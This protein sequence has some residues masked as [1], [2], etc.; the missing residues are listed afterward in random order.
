MYLAVLPSYRKE[1]IALLRNCVPRPI[2][3]CSPAH[4]EP[5]VKTGID[6]DWYRRVRMWRIAGKAFVQFGAWREAVGMGSLIVDLNPRSITAWLLLIARRLRGR[7]TLV[8]G[9][10]YPR[11][12]ELGRGGRSRLAMR[13]LADGV[14]CY[15]YAQA[16]DA[17]TAMPDRPAW[18]AP[19]ALYRA[20]QLTRTRYPGATRDAAIYVG[21]LESEKRVDLFI[22]AFAIS[23]L[24]ERSGRAIIV[25]FGKQLASLQSLV[26]CLGMRDYVE[27]HER[28]EDVDEL[29]ALY[30]RAFCSVSPGFVGLSL[31]QSF[32]FGVPAVIANGYEHSPEIELA[33]RWSDRTTWSPPTPEGF[34]AALNAV[35][36]RRHTVPMQDV[37]NDVGSRYSAEAMAAGLAEALGVDRPQ[38]L[39]VASE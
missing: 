29:A 37:I 24:A 23:G 25:G 32:G 31:T 27:F 10:L 21:R 8:W 12:H 5:S 28:T 26:D 2:L 17:A 20:A 38:G 22:R 19:N 35:F 39:E 33:H 7:R 11:A 14:I 18:V 30:A 36:L 6:S 4:L 15:T 3:Y 1:C 13:R 16:E 9:H 34:A